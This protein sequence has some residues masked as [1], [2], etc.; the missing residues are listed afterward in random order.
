M[1]SIGG[2]IKTDQRLRSANK[3]YIM[4]FQRQKSRGEDV[5]FMTD[6]FSAYSDQILKAYQTNDEFKSLCEDFYSSAL[7]LEYIKQKLLK[8][9][10]SELEY[11]RLFQDLENE[12]LDFLGTEG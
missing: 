5:K 1:P 2:L 9:K 8:D 6:R 4:E 7:I 12:I 11:R 3:T 10:R